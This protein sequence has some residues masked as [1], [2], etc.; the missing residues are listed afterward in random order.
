MHTTQE[1]DGRQ[2]QTGGLGT[3]RVNVHEPRDCKRQEYAN[4]WWDPISPICITNHVQ[5][6]CNTFAT[7]WDDLH[8]R[9][10]KDDKK[11]MLYDHLRCLIPFYDTLQC[12]F[13]LLQHFLT[14]SDAFRPFATFLDFALFNTPPDCVTFS[15][16][17]HQT[18]FTWL[19]HHSFSF[20]GIISLRSALC[21][22]PTFRVSFYYYSCTYGSCYHHYQIE[23][24]VPPFDRTTVYWPQISLCPASSSFSLTF[25][26]Y[27]TNR[28]RLFWNF[29][30]LSLQTYCLLEQHFLTVFG[31]LIIISTHSFSPLSTARDRLPSR[32]T[33]VLY[34][35]VCSVVI[36]TI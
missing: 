15:S 19:V 27:R 22:L 13:S 10:T 11:T 26:V 9:T 28:C 32:R 12:S 31:S 1:W 35:G 5:H 36:Q 4:R 17:F 7:I 34:C 30:A 14:F 16:T 2:T 8:S 25:L 3:R 20:S 21:A 33:L 24:R 29:I 6:L 18:L 23:Q